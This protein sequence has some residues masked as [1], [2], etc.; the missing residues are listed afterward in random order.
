MGVSRRASLG[1]EP[2]QGPSIVL[3][4]HCK[5]PE[6]KPDDSSAHINKSTNY[7]EF[8]GK[9]ETRNGVSNRKHLS[10]LLVE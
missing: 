8:A 3:I 1:A 2:S 10:L 6:N 5:L 9:P 4:S 7:A